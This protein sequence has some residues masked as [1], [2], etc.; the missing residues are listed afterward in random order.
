MNDPFSALLVWG[1]IVTLGIAAVVQFWK[2]VVLGLIEDCHEY[3][4]EQER[5][6]F[7]GMTC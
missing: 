6:T 5:K 3:A 7:E 2:I 4:E 1:F